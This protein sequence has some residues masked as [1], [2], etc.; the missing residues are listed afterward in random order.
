VGCSPH[1]RPLCLLLANSRSARSALAVSGRLDEKRA[2][3]S[4][5]SY[6]NLLFKMARS[7][8][9]EFY[10]KASARELRQLEMAILL[11]ALFLRRKR[12][13]AVA[14]SFPPQ[15]EE[16]VTIKMIFSELRYEIVGGE[17]F[18]A[19]SLLEKEKIQR[20]IFDRVR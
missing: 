7:D 18:S 6:R 11:T 13:L 8:F 9:P 10:T 5:D 19:L 12:S 4:P 2:D 3:V 17:T 14:G 15:D 16:S 20:A 1:P